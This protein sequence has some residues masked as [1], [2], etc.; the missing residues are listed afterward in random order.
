[1]AIG[2]TGFTHHPHCMSA[3]FLAGMVNETG[4][5]W[6][7]AHEATGASIADTL[8]GAFDSAS[9]RRGL[10][11]RDNWPR[12]EA[13]VIAPCQAVHTIG[14]RFPIDVLFVR[15]D[16]TVEKVSTA[17]RPW[18]MAGAWRGWA[19]IEFAAGALEAQEWRVQAGDRVMV[20][21]AIDA[22]GLTSR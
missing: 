18:R 1:M 2:A 12:G 14:M 4:R 7:L 8:H 10:L 13:L 15:R 9:R 17:V 21:P 3:H 6:R 20:A 5:R 11:G 19:V 22:A 16:G